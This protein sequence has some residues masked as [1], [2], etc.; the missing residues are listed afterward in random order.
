MLTFNAYVD[1]RSRVE[2]ALH[3]M[4][5]GHQV[6]HTLYTLVMS[7]ERCAAVVRDAP[8]YEIGLPE[9]LFGFT[10]VLDDRVDLAL[11]H[12]VNA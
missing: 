7:P 10:I 8:P 6:D 3:L 1:T 2:E 11:R 4:R 12:E 9:F 5:I